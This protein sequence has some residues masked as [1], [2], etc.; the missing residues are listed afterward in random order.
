LPS[1]H[2]IAPRRQRGHRDQTAEQLRAGDVPGEV[3]QPSRSTASPV[4]RQALRP[5]SHPSPAP[6][7]DDGV[8]AHALRIALDI[9]S[10]EVSRAYADQYPSTP[11]EL[12]SF[13]RDGGSPY[14][15]VA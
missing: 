4:D 1:T 10:A 12:A 3:C 6:Q 2:P 7:A 15:W 9:A 8:A 11:L 14:A 13:A 5:S